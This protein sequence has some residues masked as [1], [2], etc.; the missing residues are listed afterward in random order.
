AA[1][2]PI[3]QDLA[4]LLLGLPTGGEFDQE[5]QGAY[6]QDYIAFYVGDDWR[7]RRNLTINLGLRYDHDFPT[8]ERYNR[9]VNGFNFGANPIQSAAQAA[10]A[11]HPIPEVP[12][13]R[14]A[15]PGG[16]T[17]ASAADPYIYNTASHLFSPRVGFAWTPAGP[18]GKTTI[19]GGFAMFEFPQDITT[20]VMNQTGYSLITPITATQNNYV[21]PYATLSNPFPNGLQGPQGL[22]TTTALGTSVAFDNQHVLNPY[23]VRWDFDVQRQFGSNFMVELG[24]E[25]NHAVHL[26]ENQNINYLP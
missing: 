5:S 10:Y 20:S 21:S 15:P 19:R 8:T 16:L 22:S 13:S 17:Y 2:A 24:Y 1:A 18:D 23:S 11:L 12:V 3:G 9:N 14:F 6:R 4:A 25:G 26:G 7:I